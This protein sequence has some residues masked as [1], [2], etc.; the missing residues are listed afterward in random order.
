[1]RP[2]K[3]ATEAHNTQASDSELVDEKIY[4]LCPS[5]KA[6]TAVPSTVAFERQPDTE[7][8]ASRALAGSTCIAGSEAMNKH[9]VGSD[10]LPRILM[11]AFAR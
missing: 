7:C 1:M 5:Q 3:N 9:P 10:G 6:E 2:D 4:P 11:A 8:A